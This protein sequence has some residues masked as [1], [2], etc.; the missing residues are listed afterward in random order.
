MA[1]SVRG[2]TLL[3]K[4][5]AEGRFNDVHSFL[6]CSWGLPS[7]VYPI[8][9][10]IAMVVENNKVV[11]ISYEMKD[12]EGEIL[13]SSEESGDLD[14]LHGTR[15]LMPGLEASL[16]GKKVGDSIDEVYQPADAFGEYDESLIFTVDKSDFQDGVELYEGLEFQAD[17]RDES[18]I[19]VI[20]AIEGD[21][22]TVDANHPLADT[23]VKVKAQVKAI[24]DAS[25][26]EIEHGHAHGE[27]GHDHDEDEDEE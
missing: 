4:N 24:R 3:V 25:P 2:Q 19:C 14:Y 20:V 11:T 27:H 23:V 12:E 16:S 7:R 1:A 5:I 18:K 17:V 15:F 21:K 6:A 10:R 26:E 9:K 13:D 8:S 22:V